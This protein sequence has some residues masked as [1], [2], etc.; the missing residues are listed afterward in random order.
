[1]IAMRTAMAM[2]MAARKEHTRSQ[3]GTALIEFALILPVFLTLV[4]GMMY[5][6]MALLDKTILTMAAQQGAR[7]GAISSNSGL[8]HD[9]A[10]TACAGQLISIYGPLSATITPTIDTGA[11]KST[12]VASFDYPAF[13]IFSGFPI[14]AQTTMRLESP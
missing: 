14:S 2:L 9:A 6:S 12:V 11:K 8:A 13:Y 7:V 3:K 4:I 5:Y 10:A 1:M